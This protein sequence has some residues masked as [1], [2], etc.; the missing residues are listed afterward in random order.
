MAL[1]EMELEQLTDLAKQK[2]FKKLKDLLC[3]LNE[4]DFALDIGV[5]LS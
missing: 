4:V 2:Q 5:L 3:E 1:S